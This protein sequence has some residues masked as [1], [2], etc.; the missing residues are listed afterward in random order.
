MSV[1]LPALAALFLPALVSAIVL[2]ASFRSERW[3]RAGAAIGVGVGFA[4]GQWLLSGYPG[5]PP[6]DATQWPFWIALAGATVAVIEAAARLPKLWVYGLRSLI[7]LA[8]ISAICW[9]SPVL[10]PNK[11]ELFAWIAVLTIAGLALG[12]NAS[13]T[14][15]RLPA[16]VGSS[17]MLL[18]A[19][20]MGVVFVES[21]SATQG[22]F[23]L[24]LAASLFPAFVV[25]WWRNDASPLQGVMP[26]IWVLVPTLLA[27]NLILSE[28]TKTSAA[29]LA[30]AA[31]GAWV[32]R[33]QFLHNRSPRVQAIVTSIVVAIPL[34]VA[35]YLA[36]PPNGGY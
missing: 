34:G 20:A 15:D 16:P 1:I 29:L 28:L 35:V 18:V 32:A 4:L 12:V 23:A 25:A 6:G 9:S 8:A 11:S 31:L 2:A 13:A 17:A 22:Q 19:V 36:V 27:V 14:A 24:A 3:G 21:R 7:V 5:F 30:A 33:F 26:V 10:V